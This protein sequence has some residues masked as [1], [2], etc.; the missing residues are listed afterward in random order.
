MQV[1]KI[2]PSF[3]VLMSVYK[4][5]DPNNL[6]IALTSIEKQ[7]LEPSEIVLVEDG[8]ISV[9]LEKVI[10]K[11]KHNFTRKF[12][13][14]KLKTNKGLGNALKI[15]TKFVSTNWIVRMDADDISVPN[16]FE[17]QFD[18]IDKDPSIA[19]VGGKV[20]EFTLDI[21]NIIG[22]RNLPTSNEQIYKFAKWRSPF[23]HPTVL[24]NKTVLLSVGGYEMYGNLEDYYLWPRI[25][26]NEYRVCN[27]ESTLVFMRVDDDLY[28]RR[29]KI[30]NILYFYKLRRFMNRNHLINFY[31][32]ILGN[33]LMTIN[34]VL[35]NFMRKFVYKKIV[36]KQH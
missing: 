19:V 32:M 9:D 20:E 26:A 7:T 11:H 6:D 8:P 18:V 16:R 25:L 12:K 28:S 4:S 34:I 36:H 3:S 13:D 5:D 14:I 1:K 23:N 21:N 35:P 31:E 33:V 15:G 30:S 27:L 22:E 24:I 29:G 2:Y 17:Q 10:N